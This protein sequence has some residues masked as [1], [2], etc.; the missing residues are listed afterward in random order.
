MIHS[1]SLWNRMLA[2]AVNL[3]MEEN[4]A[5]EELRQCLKI[6]F[7]LMTE[8]QFD[9]Y[10]LL[11]RARRE[12]ASPFARPPLFLNHPERFPESFPPFE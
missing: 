10:L 7:D 4:D 9:K 3:V 2:R 1:E 8:E 11:T 12:T 5:L 6:A